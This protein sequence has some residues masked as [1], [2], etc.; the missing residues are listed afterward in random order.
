MSRKRALSVSEAK[1]L[2]DVEETSSDDDVNDPDFMPSDNDHSETD[3]EFIDLNAAQ[4]L[5]AALE[6]M[7]VHETEN[8]DEAAEEPSRFSTPNWRDYG[9]FHRSDITYTG[10][11][12]LLLN[13]T[14]NISPADVYK[15]FVD[16]EF[17]N[18]VVA[19]TNLYAQQDIAKRLPSSSSRLQKWVP[20]NAVE[21]R[22]FLGLVM[23]MGL[24]RFGEI[25]GYWRSCELYTQNLAPKTMS[26]NRFQI[27]LRSL[28][29]EDNSKLDKNDRL[30]KISSLLTTMNRNFKKVYRPG[31]TVVVDESLIPWRG[32]LVFRQFIPTKAHKYGIKLFKLC[33]AEGYTYS[34]EVYTGAK[35]KQCS[36]GDICKR[37][38][39]GL[40]HEGR[41][42]YIDNFY[43]SYKLAVYL[44]KNN[45]HTVGTLRQKVKDM[46]KK[47]MD[48]T[49]RRG[50]MV[51]Q[52]EQNGI[53]VL[54]WKDVRDVRLLST[55]HEPKMVDVQDNRQL[56]EPDPLSQ[57]GP[58]RGARQKRRRTVRK[59]EGILAYN[60]GK[61]GIDISDQ[62]ASYE[63]CLRKGLKWYRKLSISILLGMALTN[64]WL[65]YKKATNK[66]LS[67]KK[68]KE[69]ICMDHLGLAVQLTAARRPPPRSTTAPAGG[70]HGLVSVRNADGSCIRRKCKACYDKYKLEG[71]EAAR[72]KTKNTKYKC[73]KCRPEIFLCV[74]CFTEYHQI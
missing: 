64:A 44:L 29:F 14:E 50:D 66:T 1:L 63:C 40:L 70:V 6:E 61:I 34:F 42:L 20:T 32:R 39:E 72:S 73:D 47:V 3:D 30:G 68:F 21:M 53:V 74:E 51:S 33:T 25:R 56:E 28:H 13:L 67:I 41:T 36:P 12:G 35:D 54:K 23:Y 22:K 24:C 10:H 46:P 4:D 69:L 52:Q 15:L 18:L 17:I 45:T 43:T 2:L 31:E 38:M 48:A 11:E 16:D 59:P 19:Q 49:L 9:E 26:R 55:K 65:I 37:L 58:S 71:R 7:T 60:K 27:L 57:P 5:T 8:P 62:M